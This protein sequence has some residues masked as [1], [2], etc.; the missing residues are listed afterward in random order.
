MSTTAQRLQEFAQFVQAHL[1]GDEKGES[2]IFLDK[3]FRAFG[4]E[5]AV[6]AGAVY[7]ER[8]AKGSKK[9]K[10][11][12]ADLVWKPRVLIEMKKR[13]ADLSKHYSQAF[14]YWQRAVPDR[15]RYVLLCNFD[16]FWVYD[17]DT[18]ID[19]PI[20][21]VALADLPDRTAVFGF[22]EVTVRKSVFGNNQVEVTEKAAGRMGELYAMLRDRLTRQGDFDQPDMVAQ[23]F[24]LQSV[25]AMFAEDRALL[26]DSLFVQSVQD[27]L[28]GESSY[29]VLG[30]LFSAMNAPG[31]TPAGR[32]KGVDYFNGGLF[33]HIDPID[34]THPELKLLEVAALENWS[35]VRPAIFG[36]IFES[37]IDA[38]TRH[39]HGI[40]YTAEADIMKIVRPTIS[41]YWEER[42]DQANTIPEL[43]AL[44]LELQTYRVLDP[45]C[46]SGNFLYIAYQELK[47]IEQTLLDKIASRRKSPRAQIQMG[48]VTPLQ[49][50]G[51]DNNP[52][53]VELARV[54]LMIARKVAIDRLGLQDYEPALPLDTLDKNIVCQDAL[55][56]EW[57][58][59][60][61]IIG[62]PPFLGGK[63]MRLAIGDEYIDRVFQKFPD[64]K[65]SV[66][67]CAYWFRLAHDHIQENSRVGLVGTNSVSQGK[68]RI[69]ALDYVVQN[70]GHIHEAISTQPW[71]GQ[72]KVHVSIVNW[73]KQESEQNFLDNMPVRYISSSLKSS[74]DVSYA[75]LLANNSGYSFVGIQPT[76]SGFVIDSDTAEKWKKINS[77]NSDVLKLYLTGSKVTENVNG[78]PDRW[79]IDFGEMSLEDASLYKEPF[80]HVK[81]VVKPERS[82]NRNQAL[83]VT[84]WRFEKV[85]PAMRLAVENLSEFFAVSEVS[86]WAIFIPCPLFWLPG[87]T[88]KV[89]ASEDFYIFGILSSSMH[90]L[91]VSAQSST[92]KGDTRYT[93][94]TCFE[95]FPFP[96]APSAKTI[97]QIRTKAIE[98]HQYRSDQMQQKQWGITKLYNAYFHEPVSQL[99]KL[100]KQ[101]DA[102]V[103]Q[104]YGFDPTDDLLEKL[105]ALNLEVAAKEQRG[106]PAIGP[107]DPTQ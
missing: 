86:K 14:D 100:H 96:Q 97:Q 45:A 59:A 104:A 92:L 4:H 23:R 33:A 71:S 18:Q 95:T 10:T 85:R 9:G 16:E 28:G 83:Q 60:D 62:N 98:L 88:T 27:C 67:F 101:L 79:I 37:A 22:M 107:W 13:G 103:L 21:T 44:Q 39:A 69:A 91:W 72:A 50:Y 76:G 106:E 26:P 94:R 24:V 57:P 47:Q 102:L 48:F 32:F 51:I 15:P 61:A 78:T 30:N 74:V 6:E 5:G 55:F 68:S 84:W 40:H 80:E 11:G 81:Q 53:A 73:N 77:K 66:D 58:K 70:G 35:K 20:D 87:N 90:R 29:D 8:I 41:R 7:E 12:Y 99:Y 42:I 54:T 19:T 49:F 17:F 93:P 82:K 43:E 31:I 52:F 89:V 1:K 3:F 65:D 25:L 34:L 2:Q 38:K 75:S 36:S 105:L 56:T 64:V 63:Y 46:G